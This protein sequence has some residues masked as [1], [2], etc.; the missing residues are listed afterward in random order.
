[1]VPAELD[2]AR[3]VWLFIGGGIDLV[4]PPQVFIRTDKKFPKFFSGVGE[5]IFFVLT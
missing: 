3:P 2:E 5:F 4:D 1:M